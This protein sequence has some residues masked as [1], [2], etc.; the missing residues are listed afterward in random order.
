MKHLLLFFC[1][2]F[3]SVLSWAQDLHFSQFNEN[4][5]LVNPALTGANGMRASMHTRSQWRSVT[6]PY[7]TQGLSLEARN[8]TVKKRAG[9]NLENVPPSDR[10]PGRYAGGLSIYK[11]K[12]GDGRLKLTQIN[13]SFATFVPL[14]EKSAFSM[15]VQASYAVRRIDDSHFIYPNQYNSS[16]GYDTDMNSNENFATDK[17][18]YLDLGAGIM[19]GFDDEERGLKDHREKRFHIG[20]AAYHLTQPKQKFLSKKTDALY[21]KY[22]NHADLL[23]SIPNSRTGIYASY[24]VQMQASHMEII[25]GGMFRYYMKNDTRYTGYVK[26]STAAGGL[27]FRNRDALIVKGMFEWQEQ[28]AVI[29]SYDLNVSKLA[30]SSNIRGGLELTLRYTSGHPYLYQ[31]LK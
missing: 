4:P 12:A 26:R 2:C 13:G 15:G 27:Y 31:K 11:D 8:S 3:Y 23:L 24:I 28:Y 17:F 20:F 10:I 25:A 7:S 9:G 18:R 14:S 16:Y 5:S 30:R 22:V 19:Y 29:M 6:T 21:M 1:A